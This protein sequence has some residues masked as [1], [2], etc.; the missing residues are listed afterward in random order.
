MRWS[1]GA[2]TASITVSSAAVYSVTLTSPS[3]CTTSASIT[4][5]AD[6]TVAGLSL[7]ND[8]P[9]ACTANSF[10]T[11]TA[12][13]APAGSI[14]RFSPGASQAGSS[15]TATVTLAGLYSVTA[16]TPNGCLS[17]ATTTVIGA[18]CG[19]ALSGVTTIRCETID[20]VRG[21]RRVTFTPQYTGLSGE[22][23]SF[24][25]V[26]ELATTTAPGPYTMRLYNDNPV[27]TL[28]AQQGGVTTTFRY[29][30]LAGCDG[31]T[32]PTE[33]VNTP[34]VVANPIPAQTATVG[35]FFS[36]LI[37]A[38]TFT[39]AQ[40]PGQLTLRVTDLPAGLVFSAPA[41]I[42]GTPSVSGISTLTVIATDPGGLSTS[43]QLTLTVQ[44]SGIVSPPS[45]FA[46]SGVT[47]VR[48]ETVDAARGERR[49]TFTPQYMGLSGEPVSFSIVNELG[50]T[51]AA[52]P[53]TLRLY[54]DNPVIT[55][56]AQQG[57]VNSTFSYNWL[58]GCGSSQG[59]VGVLSESI[60]QVRVLGNPF[61]GDDLEL[62]VK[63]ADGQPLTVRV[64]DERG[65]PAAEL[66]YRETAQSVERLPVRVA[67]AGGVYLLQVSIPG[68]Q[69][70]VKVIKR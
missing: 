52:G 42:S 43:A 14:F 46:L 62:E 5:T 66:V 10:V 15:N 1:T 65:Y 20:A 67:G 11:L 60:L 47:T 48:C 19:F 44:P 56:V 41:T 50:A 55:L 7:T 32:P 59:R 17:T 38:G 2:T 18:N 33:P 35:Q 63:G 27:I 70:T 29:N 4:V 16:T 25:I 57:G 28:V 6:Q 9:L 31:N 36:Y 61:V 37:P 26:N 12:S 45:G 68:Q 13:G 22:P 54:S 58:V 39:D 30:W 21:E 53:Y 3:G 34:P 49:V 64:S 40:T 8:G 69:Q 24:S 51:T 23:V